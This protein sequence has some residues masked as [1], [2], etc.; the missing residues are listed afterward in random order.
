MN[1]PYGSSLIEVKYSRYKS[2]LHP[3]EVNND[4]IL[5][6]LYRRVGD[7]HLIEQIWLNVP[8]LEDED[9]LGSHLAEGNVEGSVGAEADADVGGIGAQKQRHQRQR[10][11]PQFHSHRL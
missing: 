4:N 5:N 10:R 9:T 6:I 7:L 11:Q 2:L 8:G 1:E 3:G